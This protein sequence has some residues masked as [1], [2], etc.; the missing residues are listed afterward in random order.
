MWVQLL[1]ATCCSLEQGGWL[2]LLV[3][4]E[5]LA[6]P[7]S[8]SSSHFTGRSQGGQITRDSEPTRIND[9]TGAVSTANSNLLAIAAP[10]P[11]AGRHRPDLH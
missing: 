11:F 3:C 5:A 7:I 2:Q 6:C 10:L 9:P 4:H 1:C 8:Q